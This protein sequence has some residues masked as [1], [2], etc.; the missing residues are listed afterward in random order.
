MSQADSEEARN[1]WEREAVFPLRIRDVIDAGEHPGVAHVLR[2]EAAFRKREGGKVRT[3]RCAAPVARRLRCNPADAPAPHLHVA[4]EYIYSVMER[5]PC[6][7][8][9]CVDCEGGEEEPSVRNIAKAVGGV[10]AGR[11]GGCDLTDNPL[12]KVPL[13]IDQA[14]LVTLQVLLALQ[15][16][17]SEGVVHRVSRRAPPPPGSRAF[18][19]RAGANVPVPRTFRRTS[20]RTTSSST[21]GTT[22]ARRCVGCGRRAGPGIMATPLLRSHAHPRPHPQ[23]YPLIKIADFGF[24]RLSA[25]LASRPVLARATHHMRCALPRR[26]APQSR[27]VKK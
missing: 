9:F 19:L 21:T 15:F 24:S 8:P 17:H 27:L 1:F 2:V 16:L 25:Y 18:A 14:R 20:S 12:C 10:G 5:S 26:L 6:A 3:Q 23:W 11:G 4:Q 7:K 22:R 13:S